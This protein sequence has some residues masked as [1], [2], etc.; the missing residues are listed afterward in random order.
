MCTT[1]MEHLLVM[2]ATVVV[3]KH[4]VQCIQYSSLSIILNEQSNSKNTRILIYRIY[5]NIYPGL[6]N[7]KYRVFMIMAR[8]LLYSLLYCLIIGRQIRHKW[9]MQR[10]MN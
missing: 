7:M 9:K 2:P 4:K 3:T 6:L 5:C 8:N 10:N 1:L